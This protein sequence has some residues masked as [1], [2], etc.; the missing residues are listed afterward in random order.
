MSADG[1]CHHCSTLGFYNCKNCSNDLNNEI[2]C[3]E[4]DK[5]YF[6]SNEGKCIQCY[7]DQVKGPNNRCI[8]CNDIEN[9]GV[10]GCQACTNINNQI[11]CQRCYEDSILYKDKNICLK[12]NHNINFL[13]KLYCSQVTK[14][15]IDEFV[16][17]KCQEKYALLKE[18]S[19]TMC[20]RAEYFEYFFDFSYAI[21]CDE[22]I[23]L[24]TEEK[25]K[26]TCNKCRDYIGYDNYFKGYTKIKN[27]TTNT[28]FCLSE[29]DYNNNN[30]KYKAL[31]NCLEA[32]MIKEKDTMKF[33]CTKCKEN[34]I[35]KYYE[36]INS[37]ICINTFNEEGEIDKEEE[38]ECMIK[39]CR[40]C[41]KGNNYVCKICLP[42]NY[43]VNPLTGAC[44][45]KNR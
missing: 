19:Y 34:S 35:L 41:E 7:N 43:E 17:T 23:N 16:C 37:S 30:E 38:E 5:G 27:L 31:E 42:S 20:I 39:Y 11:I 9:G 8:Q 40:I 29:Y 18:N 6:L 44:V 2:I 33:N 15:N 25:P 12:K 13:K 14:N 10:E 24:G 3:V 36:E 28:S 1:T 45:K 21:S 4:C 32:T 26:Y 22:F